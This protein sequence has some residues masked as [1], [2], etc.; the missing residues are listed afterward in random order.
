MKVTARVVHVERLEEKEQE[1]D[2]KLFSKS[3]SMEYDRLLNLDY[4]L[5]RFFLSG[6]GSL[7]LLH[8]QLRLC[9]ADEINKDP[10]AD[11]N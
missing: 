6:R 10:R 7:F 5:F 1:T 9:L 8:L 11:N 2:L 4:F 3:V